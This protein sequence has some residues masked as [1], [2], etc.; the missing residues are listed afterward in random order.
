MD[1]RLPLSRRRRWLLH[2]VYA[3]AVL[4]ALGYTVRLV[5]E[6]HAARGVFVPSD[7]VVSHVAMGSSAQAAGARVGDP[8]ASGEGLRWRDRPT[9]EALRVIRDGRE[10]A[11]Q[12]EARSPTLVQRLAMLPWYRWVLLG[13]GLATL[14]IGWWVFTRNPDAPGSAP[15]VFWTAS[16]ALVFPMIGPSAVWSLGMWQTLK[17]WEIVFNGLYHAFTLHWLVLF[18]RR[19]GGRRVVWVIY[20]AVGAAMLA[21]FAFSPTGYPEAALHLRAGVV[22]LFVLVLCGVQYARAPTRRVRRQAS[23]VL[24]TAGAYAILDTLLWE[25]PGLL[26]VSLGSTGA[27]NAL[28]GLSYLLIPAGIA[29]AVTR[30]GLFGIDRFVTPGLATGASLLLLAVAYASGAAALS[31]ALGARGSL[32]IG[33]GVALAVA[34]A[35]LLVPLQ[36]AMLRVLGRVFDRHERQTRDT[37]AAFEAASG[38]AV[39]PEALGRALTDTLREGLGLTSCTLTDAPLART[40]ARP[41]VLNVA[42]ARGLHLVPDLDVALAVPLSD[43][44]GAIRLGMRVGGARFHDDHLALVEDLGRRY[45]LATERLRLVRQLSARDLDL[46]NT[47]LR[48]AGDLH[49]DI[50][51]SLSSMAVLSDLVR[52]NGDLPL[53]DRARLDRLSSS[54][55]DLVG[56][57]RD[58]VWSIDP[59]SDRVHDLAERLRD[60]CSALLPGVRCTVAAPEA[61]DLPLGMETRRQL[62]LVAKEALHN[63]ARHAHAS[64]VHIRLDV[65]D[66]VLALSI[67]DDGR[68]FDA[69]GASTGHGLGSLAERAATLGGT[70]EIE[71]APGEGARIRLIAPRASGEDSAPEADPA[72]GARGKTA[73]SR[74]DSAEDAGLS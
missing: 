1:A 26:G 56:D 29:V 7:G 19:L 64:T 53:A 24:L 4:G 57:L 51:A 49:D 48:I 13:V 2:L 50:G 30:E 70:V 41:G 63:V 39:D 15:F 34:L 47:R 61:A 42:D 11:L 66:D 28:V 62:L 25:L 67:A 16:A 5:A 31:S 59:G 52:R 74:P 8:L 69:S 37:T 72:S 20:G 32:P 33:A 22:G 21:L 10:V 71:S 46:A 44:S 65:S 43:A 17:V 6:P 35:A 12:M 23:W 58:I 14:G 36:R 38:A 3:S 68:G 60:T 55:R 27:T 45:V 73:R 18:P 54:A 9:P 40:V